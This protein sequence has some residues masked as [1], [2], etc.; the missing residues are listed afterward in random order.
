MPPIDETCRMWPRALLA[1]ERQRRLG[2]PERAEEVG[3]HLVAD[4]GLAELLDHAELAVAGVVDD[5]V[6]AA[7]LLVRR[8][9][10]GERA[11]P[12]GDVE[13]AAAAAGRRTSRRGRRGSTV[14]RA[15]AATESPRSRAA[16]AHSR[17]KPR[18]A[19]VMN[20]I[21]ALMSGAATSTGDLF[22]SGRRQRPDS[23]GRR[24]S[25]VVPSAASRRR[26]A[27]PESAS[28]TTRLARNDGDLG[29]VVGRRDLDHVHP[30]DRQLVGDAAHRVEQL[31][32]GQPAGLGRAGAGRVAGVAHVDVD[33][34]EHP[35]AVVDGDRE[36]L[37][38]ALRRGRARRSR[39]SRRSASAARPS[40]PAS[41][42]RGQ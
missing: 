31:P 16:I 15:V 24:G 26:R 34:E 35:V 39:S 40:S 37:G 2:D 5:D 12:V 22:R 28:S 9:D 11:V 32:G 8:A 4:V 21:F 1:Q 19:P 25:Q 6:E 7:E 36:R 41:P 29:V 3:L 38:Q 30:D 42:G 17:P 27:I 18:D 10:R 14:S 33:R 20:Q 23:S 13:A